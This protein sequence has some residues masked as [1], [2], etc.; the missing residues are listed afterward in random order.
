MTAFSPQNS[1]GN[2]FQNNDLK[3]NYKVL[4]STVAIITLICAIGEPWETLIVIILHYS[5]L[6]HRRSLGGAASCCVHR[7]KMWH[8]THL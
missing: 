3:C 1:A 4:E 8:T 5:I 7:L 6:L 2:R